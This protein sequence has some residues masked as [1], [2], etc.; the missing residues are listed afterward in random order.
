MVEVMFKDKSGGCCHRCRVSRARWAG[1]RRALFAGD[2][3]N[4]GSVSDFTVVSYA[5]QFDAS[6]YA[7]LNS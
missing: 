6:L 7:V 1:W 2:R 5:D 3:G 4:R